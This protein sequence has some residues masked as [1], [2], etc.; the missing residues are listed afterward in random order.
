M[1]TKILNNYFNELFKRNLKREIVLR[2]NLDIKFEE[3]KNGMCYLYLKP[4]KY[5]NYTLFLDW[6]KGDSLNHLINLQ[7]IEINYILKKLKN[8]TDDDWN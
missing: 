7:K 4:T 8:M 1:I 3:E 2:F 5:Q 6:H